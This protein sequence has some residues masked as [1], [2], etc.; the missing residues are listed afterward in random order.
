MI[1]L[2]LLILW[3]KEILKLPKDT[4]IKA[5]ITLVVLG[6]IT[7]YGTFFS[8]GGQRF[9]YISVF[10]D[11]TIPTEVGTAR[12]RD[13]LM[14]GETGLGLSPRVSD[15]FFHNKVIFWSE[16]ISRNILQSFSTDFLFIKGDL[17]LRHSIDGVGQFYRIEFITMVLGFLF[18]FS[19]YKDKR[20][21]AFVALWLFF[22]V[23]PAAITRI[24]GNHA[25]RL[26]LIL[27]PLVFLISY[28]LVETA[29]MLKGNIKKLF[30]LGYFG[31]LTLSFAAYQHEFWVHN[32][33]DSERW[34][35]TGFEESIGIIKEIDK[36]YDKVILSMANEPVWIFFAGWYEYPPS[37]W[38]QGFP[39]EKS[40]LDGF[41]DL[42][43]IDK[44]YFAAIREVDGGIF[45][46]PQ[47]IDEKTLY[48]AV[49]SEIGENLIIDPGKGPAGL[50][51]IKAISYPSGE[52]AFYLFTKG[53]K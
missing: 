30:L 49:A 16:N 51:L 4:L 20:I 23:L 3:R 39:F 45:A 21:K 48:L 41:G 25:T 46:L 31:L 52:P 50:K 34:W 36:D 24:G 35:H 12:L 42:S 18:F 19:R 27:P 6:G 8:G 44:Y 43:F 22:G 9:G 14:R 33:W 17:N 1:L 40:Y 32:P 47:Y 37:Q 26:I 5:V 15:R 53:E 10:S 29:R 11:P 7:T 13:S 2:G 28:G 38:H